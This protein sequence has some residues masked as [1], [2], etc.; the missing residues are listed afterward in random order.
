MA[1]TTLNPAN[2]KSCQ[3]N[4]TAC[5]GELESHLNG[6][7]GAQD[8]LYAAVKGQTGNAI[9]QAMG[10]AYE[11]GKSLAGTLQQICDEMGIT[12]ANL[13]SFDLEGASRI[14]AE[15]GAD[16]EAA[17]GAADG[18]VASKVDTRSW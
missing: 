14:H 11:S 13:D 2:V 17:T 1:F 9:Y 8:E 7:S 3:Q 5:L 4:A 18:A 12:S 6:M 16:G 10:R 15:A